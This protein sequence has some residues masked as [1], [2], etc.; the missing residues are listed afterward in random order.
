[1]SKLS[2]FIMSVQRDIHVAL[3]FKSFDCGHVLDVSQNAAIGSIMSR[4]ELKKVKDGA[5]A[6]AP[7]VETDWEPNTMQHAKV[8]FFVF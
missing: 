4:C 7:P 3:K 1:M 2:N 6:D 5:P 8:I